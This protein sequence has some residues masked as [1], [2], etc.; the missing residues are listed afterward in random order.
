MEGQAPTRVEQPEIGHTLNLLSYN[1]D[2]LYSFKFEK[3][4]VIVVDPPADI[5]DEDGNQI[6]IPN[7]TVSELSQNIVVLVVPYFENATTIQILDESNGTILQIDIS[8]YSTNQITTS[9]L[10]EHED[11]PITSQT[12]SDDSYLLFGAICVGLLILALILGFVIKYLN[13]K[14]PKKQKN[15]SPTK[16]TKDKYCHVCGLKIKIGANFCSS[17]GAKIETDMS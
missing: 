3:E 17:C 15:K 16:E 2:V 11:E 8:Q 10:Q 4:A 13:D 12:E 6:I 5:F 9:T 14:K 7:D 1:G